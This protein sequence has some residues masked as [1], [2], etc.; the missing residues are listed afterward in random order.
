MFEEVMVPLIIIVLG[1]LA[2]LVFV[3]V[4]CYKVAP[5][6]KALIITGGRKPRIKVGGGGLVIPVIRKHVYFDLCMITVEA[7]G[8][9]IKTTTG[10]PIIVNW[11]AQIRPDSEHVDQ[12]LIAARSFLERGSVAITNDIKLTLDGGVREV[13]AGLTPE[14][15]LREKD[16]F[17]NKIRN[18]VAEEMSNM[19]FML[20][21]LNIQDV[22]DHNGYFDHLATEDME[23]KR[24]EAAMVTASAEQ[25]IRQRH[26]EAEKLAKETELLSE[27][28]VAKRQRD[29]AVGMAEMKTETDRAQADANIAGELQTTVRRRELAEQEGQVEVTRQIQANLAAQKRKEVIATEAEAAKRRLEIEADAQAAVVEKEATARAVAAKTE[30][31]GEA[32]ALRSRAEAEA[33]QIALT[34]KAEADVIRQKGDA[35]AEAIKAKM[36]AEAE[37]ERALA[38]ARAANDGVNFKVAIAEIQAEAQIKVATATA[39]VMATIGTN[40]RFVHFG[41]GNQSGDG[42]VLF[43]TL[44]G[45]PGLMEKLNVANQAINPDSEEFNKTLNKL[46][47]SLVEPMG[48]LNK[49]TVVSSDLAAGKAP[50]AENTPQEKKES[51]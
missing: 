30:A 29:N 18:S 1:L 31:L 25:A 32:E 40:A 33:A 51:K 13:V 36:L 45:V 5:V 17:S 7:A 35:D 24:Q 12:L 50:S 41:G 6:D 2:F 43:D 8:D 10:V 47:A 23:A 19:G 4:F 15:V 48:A 21:S 27:L 39:E 3:W 28:A 44:L 34:G 16:A 9:E 26:A 20:V 14:Q 11:T 42:N 22:T 46:V 37:G 49:Q 38:D